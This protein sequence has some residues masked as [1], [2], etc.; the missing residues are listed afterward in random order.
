MPQPAAPQ[1]APEEK[2]INSM[3]SLERVELLSQL[4]NKYQIELN[5]DEFSRIKD[6]R[7]LAA[8]IDRSKEASS[9]NV[10]EGASA[11]PPSEWARWFPVRA[12]RTTF[13]QLVAIPLFKHYLPLTVT[14]LEHLEGLE[15]PVIFAAN[16]TSSLDPVAVLASLPFRWRRRLAP[17]MGL[18]VF[19]AYFEPERFPVSEVWWTGLGYY[20]ALGLFNAYPLPQDLAGV[21][22]ALNYTGELIRRG[23][24]PL[25]FP[26]G[27]RTPDG[28]MQPFRPGIGMMAIRLGVP[29]VPV[30]INGLFE[31]YSVHD[32]W[33]KRGPVGV[34]FGQ[35]HEFTSEAYGE[36]ADELRRAILIKRTYEL[37][38][39]HDSSSG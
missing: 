34:S 4:E 14:G 26:E 3:S 29:V 22:R 38:D 25:V 39:K 33:P 19:Q 1:A 23:Y 5:E 21:R 18:G 15:P 11:R 7:E 36:A 2:D 32:S 35:P 24:C 16:H 10:T 6:R 27:M 9:A 31:I 28:K 8:W 37:P 13:Q 30:Y 12:V 20:L 17:A